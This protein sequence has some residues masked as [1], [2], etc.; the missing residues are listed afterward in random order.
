MCK[1]ELTQTV[2]LEAEKLAARPDSRIDLS[3]M[4][5]TPDWS[6]A[7][8]GRFYRPMKHLRIKEQ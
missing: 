5:E 8:R 3:D 6:D 2:Q 1:I 4:I 7:E